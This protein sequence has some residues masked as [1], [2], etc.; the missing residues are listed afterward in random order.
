MFL[1]LLLLLLFLSEG[2][3]SMVLCSLKLRENFRKL[4]CLFP[5]LESLGK[6]T[7]RGKVVEEFQCFMV[8]VKR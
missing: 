8:E 6:L 1:V 5:G 3:G 7:F 2:M 4:R